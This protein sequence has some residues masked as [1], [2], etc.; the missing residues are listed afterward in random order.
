MRRKQEIAPLFR[1]KNS[2]FKPCSADAASSPAFATL[3]S[4]GLYAPPSLLQDLHVLDLLELAGSQAKAGAALAMHQSTVCR[5][6]RLMQRELQLI[7]RQ[8]QPVCRHGHNDCL[9]HLRL[10]YR[11]HRLMDDVV[12]I[13]CDLLHHPL[14]STLPTVQQVPTRFRSAEQWVDLIRHGL[15]DGAIVS[16]YGFDQPVLSGQAPRWAG[17]KAKPLGVLALQLV[18]ITPLTRRVLLPSCAA[19]PLLHQ[20]LDWA[21]FAIEKQPAAC[22]DTAAWLKR[23]TDRRLALPVIPALVGEAWLNDHGLVPLQEQP[24]LIEQLWLLLP[25]ASGSHNAVQQLVRRL[26]T[27]IKASE[28]MQ[29]PHEN[30]N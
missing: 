29:D 23:A 24:P 8:G 16:S 6:L 1:T 15:L 10:A 17:I 12:R 3:T 18:A 28:T 7:P 2:W 25:E 22:Q 21:G 14:I 26:R 9:Q 19:A 13:G 5:S 11:A 4:P 30:A 27:R 20:T